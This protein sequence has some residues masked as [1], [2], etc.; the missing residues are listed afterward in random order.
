[1]TK[2]VSYKNIFYCSNV[3]SILRYA[4]GNF[5]N[6][7]FCILLF[8]IFLFFSPTMGTAG[9]IYSDADKDIFKLFSEVNETEA[10]FT[11]VDEITQLI[12]TRL[13]CF[14][15]NFSYE[16]RVTLCITDYRDNIIAVARQLIKAR[17]DVGTFLK[18]L[19]YCPIM[20]NLCQGQSKMRK[21]Q[22]PN[23]CITFER[24]CIDLMLDKYWRGFPL[25]N[26]VELRMD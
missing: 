13:Q 19:D 2:S 22:D 21:I 18:N 23:L 12:K 6:K 17:P 15:D 1:M 14:E 24:K 20:H 9:T 4:L 7:S 8:Y 16:K 3:F 5:M 10:S 26:N 25:Y 11:A